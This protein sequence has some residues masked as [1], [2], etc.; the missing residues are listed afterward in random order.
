MAVGK[1]GEGRVFFPW[2]RRRGLRSLFGRARARQVLLLVGAVALFLVL[3]A[4]EQRAAEVRATRAEI[5]DASRAIAAW[6]ADHDHACPTSLADLVTAG[7]L[8][9]VPRDA[10]GHPLRVTCP[11]RRDPQGFD[12]SSDG[13]DG[14]PGGTDRVE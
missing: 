1:G 6:R 3:R 8:H 12:V 5:G 9:Q 10:W 14:E 11:G 4:R 13:P 2:E 7:Y